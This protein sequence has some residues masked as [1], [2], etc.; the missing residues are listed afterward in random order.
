MRGTCRLCFTKTELLESHII[1]SF[2]YKWLKSTSGTG[3]LRFGM[4]PNRRAQDGHKRFWLCGVCEAR[5]NYWETKFANTSFIIKRGKYWKSP[6]L[7]MVI[8]VLRF[9]FMAGLNVTYRGGGSQS[10]PGGA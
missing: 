4:E 1:P 6:V 3:F 9:R 5:L 8:E 2:V 10:F 7:F